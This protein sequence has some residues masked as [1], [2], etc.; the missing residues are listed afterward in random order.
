LSSK[1]Q[2]GAI[3]KRH[4]DNDDG[5]KQEYYLPSKELRRQ[6]VIQYSGPM[7]T[8]AIWQS[9]QVSCQLANIEGAT[10]PWTYMVYI[11]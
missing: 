9:R 3:T 2:K 4:D 8:I 6:S 5:D 1:P 11:P 10:C 7:I